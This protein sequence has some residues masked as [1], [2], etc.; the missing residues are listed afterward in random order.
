MFSNARRVLSQC[1]NTRVT[2]LYLLKKE[3]DNNTAILFHWFLILGQQPIFVNAC[4]AFLN[5]SNIDFFSPRVRRT[6]REHA[7]TLRIFP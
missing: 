5:F 6:G 7:M 2:V 4:N 1:I 3:T